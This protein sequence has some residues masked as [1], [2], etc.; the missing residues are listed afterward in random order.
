VTMEPMWWRIEQVIAMGLWKSIALVYSLEAAVTR[1][2]SFQDNSEPGRDDVFWDVM[3]PA[4]RKWAA[5]QA[6]KG[7]EGEKRSGKGGELM[8]LAPPLSFAARPRPAFGAAARHLDTLPRLAMKAERRYQRAA[9]AAAD[10]L[11]DLPAPGESVHCPMLGTFDLR[12]VIAATAKRLPELRHLRIATLGYSKRNVAEL[13]A[14]LEG[15]TAD[16]RAQQG[17]ARARGRGPDAAPPRYGGRGPVA[18][19]CGVLRPRRRRRAGVRGGRPTCAPTRT[20]SNLAAVRD[21]TLHDWHAA[22]IDTLVSRDDGG[23][24]A[25][26]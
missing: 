2:V 15:R 23:E 18:L 12:Q 14:P 13:C 25:K 6:R 1:R 22:W 19:Q 11:P 3:S 9:R 26:T 17:A 16:P 4:E 10:L 8:D 21:R 20:A 24:E 5:K 7:G